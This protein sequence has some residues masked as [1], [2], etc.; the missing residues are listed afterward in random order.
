MTSSH[1][2]WVG[3]FFYTILAETKKCDGFAKWGTDKFPL[4]IYYS[5]YM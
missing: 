4:K 5:T 3:V 1:V 2:K